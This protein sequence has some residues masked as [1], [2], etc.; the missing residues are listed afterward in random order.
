MIMSY[1]NCH[2]PL[3]KNTLCCFIANCKINSYRKLIL[4]LFF[5][6]HPDRAGTSEDLAHWLH[7]GSS[8]FIEDLLIELEG[9]EIIV[10]ERGYYRLANKLKGQQCTECL[11]THFEDPL[12]RQNL[13]EQIRNQ[14]R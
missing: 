5:F 7:L 4:L 13:L 11:L 6:Q 12:A 3:K 2:S 8:F 9:E 1:P 14:R 10:Q